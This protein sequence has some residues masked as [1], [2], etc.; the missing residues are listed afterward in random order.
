MYV[1]VRCKLHV[2]STRYT[3]T[4]YRYTCIGSSRVQWYSSLFCTGVEKKALKIVYWVL[5]STLLLYPG[6]TGATGTVLLYYV[7]SWST[8]YLYR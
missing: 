3:T 5:R 8:C 4:R 7:Y 6:N 2:T 1:Q